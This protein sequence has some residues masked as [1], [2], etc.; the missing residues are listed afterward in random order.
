MGGDRGTR[1]RRNRGIAFDPALLSLLTS[2]GGAGRQH[3]S[4]QTHTQTAQEQPAAA[5]PVSPP[6]EEEFDPCAACPKDSP[7]RN[8]SLS[9]GQV[10]ALAATFPAYI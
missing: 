6:E 8:S 4:G 10:Q 5:Q 2:L 7:R 1:G 3:P 9:F